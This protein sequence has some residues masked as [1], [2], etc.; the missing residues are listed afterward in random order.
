MHIKVNGAGGLYSYL[1]GICSIIQKYY[2]LSNV[3]FSG[4]SAGCIP[5]ILLCLNLNINDEMEFINKP[6]L[7]TL[8]KNKTKAYFNFIPEL[9]NVLLTRFDSI[10]YYIYKLANNKMFCNL[11]HIPSFKNH[12][13][14]QYKNNEDLVHCLLASGHIPIYNNTFFYTYN[15]KYYVDGGL[16]KAL[17]TD[18]LYITNNTLELKTNMFRE[19]DN[20]F[21]FIKTCEDYSNKLYLLGQE[22]ALKNLKLFDKYLLRKK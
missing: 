13:Y 22:D 21:I 5:A 4:Y 20:S 12:I 6:L 8:K 10:S 9:Y 1:L 7:L 18:T 2:D 19:H 15:N 14:S 11:T 3:I 17:N 16:S